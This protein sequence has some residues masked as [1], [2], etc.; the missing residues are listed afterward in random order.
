MSK[1]IPLTQGKFAIVDDKD[2][3]LVSRFSWHHSKGYASARI[4]GKLIKMHRLLMG[5]VLGQTIDHKDMNGLNNRR[6]NLRFCTRSQNGANSRI[7]KN[8]SSGFKCIDW[9]KD[10]KKW[11]A[12]VH[13]QYG[14]VHL[15]YFKTRESAAEAH[16]FAS[17]MLFG[18]FARPNL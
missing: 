15:G 11:R 17:I 18:E 16:E 10:K 12:R 8:N 6:S 5:A 9:R 2:F 3:R 14:S 7:R 4:N 13:I 1:L